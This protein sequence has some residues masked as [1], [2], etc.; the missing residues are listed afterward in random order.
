MTTIW[1]TIRTGVRRFDD[2]T[3]VTFNPRF[4]VGSRD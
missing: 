3:L 4:P 1:S 2:W